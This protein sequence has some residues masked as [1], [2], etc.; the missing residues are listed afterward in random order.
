MSLSLVIPPLQKDVVFRYVRPKNPRMGWRV[1]RQAH[2]IPTLISTLDQFIGV[3]EDPEV[4]ISS[5]EWIM[6][7]RY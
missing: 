6:M 1:R 7:E 3:V 4:F 2:M 5:G